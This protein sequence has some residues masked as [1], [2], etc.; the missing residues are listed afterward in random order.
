MHIAIIGGSGFVGSV[1]TQTLLYKDHE[2]T[3]LSRNPTPRQLPKT[4]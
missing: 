4:G 2:V 3:V 1:L